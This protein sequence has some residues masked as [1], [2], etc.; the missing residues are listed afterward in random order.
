MS[1]EPN[2]GEPVTNGPGNNGNADKLA[3]SE[4]PESRPCPHFVSWAVG[5]LIATCAV[6]FVLIALRVA[7]LFAAA[8]WLFALAVLV[9]CESDCISEILHWNNSRPETERTIL[10]LISH[11]ENDPPAHRPRRRWETN[12]KEDSLST[13][14]FFYESYQRRRCR[15][16]E[17]LVSLVLAALALLSSPFVIFSA[18]KRDAVPPELTQRLDQIERSINKCLDKACTGTSA[19]NNGGNSTIHLDPQLENELLEYL[20]RVLAEG[21]GNHSLTMSWPVW[22]AIVILL[23]IAVALFIPLFKKHPE[24]LAPITAT[25]IA[26]AVIDKTHAFSRFEQMDWWG[27]AL[28]ACFGIATLA[29][30]VYLIYRPLENA[31]PLKS[32]EKNAGSDNLKRFSTFSAYFFSIYV[33][34][35]VFVLVCFHPA[36]LTADASQHTKPPAHSQLA[37]DRYL[38]SISGFVSNESKIFPGILSGQLP[39]KEEDDLVNAI[40]KDSPGKGDMLILIGS[41][42]CRSS[43]RSYPGGNRTLAKD[44][45]EFVQDKLSDDLKP[46]GLSPQ[47]KEIDMHATCGE[48]GSMRAVHSILVQIKQTAQ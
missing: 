31:A 32:G 27:F 12:D 10:T 35:W 13:T 11:L 46:F 37:I 26:K 20:K 21:N 2:I 8:W 36:E 38:P 33:L 28:L 47:I 3:A 4:E 23:A 16:I 17:A 34:V 5:Y 29:M 39:Q 6:A 41:T 44:R 14:Q 22:I 24:A 45:A 1:D 7:P 43:D 42:D 30:G 48:T 25:V 9:V 15:I 18:P 19:I 40:R